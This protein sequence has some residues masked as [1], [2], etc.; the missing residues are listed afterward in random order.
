MLFRSGHEVT[1][2]DYAL[3]GLK[4]TEQLAEQYNVKVKTG[5]KDLIND[6][7]PTEEFD[8]AIMVFGHFAK[9]DQESIFDKLISTVKPGGMIMLEVYSEDQV[10]YQTGG[11]KTEDM[12]YNPAD[13]LE[14]TKGY[15]MLHFFYG[16]EDRVEG[17]LHTGKGHVVQVIFKKETV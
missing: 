4:K 1:A 7:V 8:A 16:E 6:P 17:T 10:R 14:W 13:L 12:L 11:P 5:Q 9:K 15:K 3:N 2:W